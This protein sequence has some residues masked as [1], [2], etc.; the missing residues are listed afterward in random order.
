[1]KILHGD[2]AWYSSKVER[3]DG[4]VTNTHVMALLVGAAGVLWLGRKNNREG[5]GDRLPARSP[6]RRYVIVR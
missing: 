1:M 2:G 6:T 3:S 4:E 5:V